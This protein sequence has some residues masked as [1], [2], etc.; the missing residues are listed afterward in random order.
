MKRLLLLLL[1]SALPIFAHA[2]D[3]Q[4]I[5]YTGH[6]EAADKSPGRVFKLTLMQKGTRVHAIFFAADLNTGGPK[7]T[8]EGDGRV[9]DKGVLQFKFKD[10]LADEGTAMLEPAGRTYRFELRVTKFTDPGALHFY[11]VI[12]M[13]KIGDAGSSPTTVT[14]L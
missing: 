8:G 3:S 13:K 14:A 5:N 2:S 12:S 1:A 6:Y 4:K 11:G 9:D 10:N 7:P